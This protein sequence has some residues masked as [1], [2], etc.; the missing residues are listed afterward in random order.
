MNKIQ[1]EKIMCKQ[2][3]PEENTEQNTDIAE[4]E[5]SI[6]EKEALIAE[7]EASITEKEAL[8][9]EKKASIAEKKFLTERFCR[10]IGH[11]FSKNSFVEAAWDEVWRTAQY[12]DENQIPEESTIIE[13]S[14]S[15]VSFRELIMKA[16]RSSRK[17][18]EETGLQ[19]VGKR[20]FNASVWK[21]TDWNKSGGKHGKCSGNDPAESAEGSSLNGNVDTQNIIKTVYISFAKREDYEDTE[22]TAGNEESEK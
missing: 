21:Q 20:E 13:N 19:S 4:K 7:K 11:G 5:A 22:D 8:I 14:R 6:A 15:T 9:A 3:A 16:I 2:P 17:K 1:K 12:L 18:W 10:H